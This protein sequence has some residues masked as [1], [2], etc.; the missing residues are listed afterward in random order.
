MSRRPPR[1]TL[2]PYTTLFRSLGVGIG[3]LRGKALRIAHMGHVN[4]PTM[5]GALGVIEMGLIALDIPHGSGGT[6]K[7]IEYLGK[8]VKA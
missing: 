8:N 2:F 5:L 3:D 1:S 4:A 6:Q 7:A